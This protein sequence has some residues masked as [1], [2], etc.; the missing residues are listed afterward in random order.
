MKRACSREKND[1]LSEVCHAVLLM[2]GAD[3]PSVIQWDI[4]KNRMVLVVK[5]SLEQNILTY[6]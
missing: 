1:Y 2:L 5:V 3:M 4:I 6:I